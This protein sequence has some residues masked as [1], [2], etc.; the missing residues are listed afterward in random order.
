MTDLELT[1]ACAEAM[2]IHLAEHC[3]D[4]LPQWAHRAWPDPDDNKGLYGYDPLH[5]KAQCLSL[6]ETF[7][8]TI[9]RV[10]SIDGYWRARAWV[11]SLSYEADANSLNR[12]VCTAVANRPAK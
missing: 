3:G 2:G 5:D 11:G 8:M 7:H 12:A 1:K 9:T 6:I 10:D 4:K